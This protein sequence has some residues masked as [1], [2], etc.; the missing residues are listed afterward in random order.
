MKLEYRLDKEDFLEYQLYAA[1][2]SSRIKDQRRKS[3][4][5]VHLLFLSLGLIFYWEGEMFL[6]Y[7]CIASLVIS[8]IFYPIYLKNYYKRHYKNFIEDTYKNRFGK[9]TTV[10]FNDAYIEANS[11]SGESKIKL[12]ELEAIVEIQGYFYIKLKSGVTL[13]ISK[14]KLESPHLVKE[15]LNKIAQNLQVSYLTDLDWKWR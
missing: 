10:S 12:T 13:I 3:V 8:I 1:S 5:I 7:C 6:M 9:T 2:K 11:D 4:L 15:F 14:S